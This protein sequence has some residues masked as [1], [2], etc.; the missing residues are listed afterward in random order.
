MKNYI[1][2]TGSVCVYVLYSAFFPPSFW[3]FFFAFIKYEM[4]GKE[5]LQFK[6]QEKVLNL[7]DCRWLLKL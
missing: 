7:D 5:L 2:E 3:G 6:A 1:W 4:K